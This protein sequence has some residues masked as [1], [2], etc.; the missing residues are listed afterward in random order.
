[1]EIW[2]RFYVKWLPNYKIKEYIEKFFTDFTDFKKYIKQEI[3][4]KQ[5]IKRK[6][7]K[8]TNY[9]Q[10]LKSINLS[11][12][13]IEKDTKKMEKALNNSAYLGKTYNEALKYRE[14]IKNMKTN[15]NRQRKDLN[16]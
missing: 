6:N 4:S 12:S 1:M 7:T 13:N 16:N 5:A 15:I 11:L 10:K 2:L 14:L 9:L 3:K 8:T